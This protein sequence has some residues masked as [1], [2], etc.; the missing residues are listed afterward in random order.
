MTHSMIRGNEEESQ[1]QE[2][3]WY[4]LT[5]LMLGLVIGLILS[6]AVFPM[7]YTETTPAMLDED[8]RNDYIIA[9]AMAHYGTPDIGRARARLQTLELEDDV[10]FMLKTLVIDI[11]EDSGFT[12]VVEA[13]NILASDLSDGA[14]FRE[15][16]EILVPEGE[17]TPEPTDESDFTPTYIDEAQ[18]VSGEQQTDDQNEAA[19]VG[20]DPDDLA[21]DFLQPPENQVVLAMTN[22]DQPFRLAERLTFCD[23]SL[24]SQLEV[25]VTDETG[26]GL[27]GVPILIQWADGTETFYTG[28]YGEIDAGYADY[29]LQEGE[30]YQLQVGRTSLF[31]EDVKANICRED[32]GTLFSGGIRLVFEPQG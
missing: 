28:L 15:E 13:L 23:R 22:H 21:E 5:G 16:I 19:E 18:P 29:T 7:R 10:T 6:L 32:D 9:I 27:K 2:R 24:S 31:V 14:L 25:V 20:N 1:P 12:Q 8:P 11:R 17:E 4:L 30:V 3:P 26:Q